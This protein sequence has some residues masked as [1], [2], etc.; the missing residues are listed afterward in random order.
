[1]NEDEFYK[2][3]AQAKGERDQ[4]M[5][6]YLEAC[7]A[8]DEA[9]RA[10]SAEVQQLVKDRDFLRNHYSMETAAMLRAELASARA[11]IERLQHRIATMQESLSMSC[12]EPLANCEC[13]GCSYAR[14]K[15]GDV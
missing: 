9:Q 15:G 2:Q 10:L 8:R 6:D 7:R 11:E 1:M 12:E 13:A 5:R 3:L 14:E 4:A